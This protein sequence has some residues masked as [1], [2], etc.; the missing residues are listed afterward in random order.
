MQNTK[1]VPV[2]V[3]TGFL[4]SGKTTLLNHILSGQHNKKIAV[5]E[6]E[7]GEIGIDNELVI[8][9]DEEIFSLENGCICCTVRGDL[10]R[11]LGQLM[12]RKDKFDYILLETTG[13]ANPAPVAQTFFADEEMK[14]QFALDAIVT[15]VDSKFVWQ[16]ID[17]SPECQEQIAFADVLLLN[18]TDLVSEEE[19]QKLET[20][21]RQMNSQTKIY[22]S[23]KSEIDINLL[24]NV[25]AFDLENKALLNPEF[26]KKEHHDHEHDHGH[27]HGHHHHDPNHY[28]HEHDLA[29]TS[30]GLQKAGNL[31]P[32]RL[33]E[34]LS[35]LLGEKGEDIFRMKG[36][37]SVKGDPF[38]FIFQGVHMMFDQTQ[39]KKWES[40]S[41]RN[42]QLV[43]IGKNLDRKQLT[44]DF[45]ACFV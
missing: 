36:I 43:F 21:I 11:I 27:D 28:Y 8:S 5:I 16:H 10:I 23:K 15:V 29:V 25:R 22:R 2:T 4:G 18:K 9:A 6:N 24:L 20:R 44:A 14:E 40:D 26:L 12:R 1:K 39:G 45:E 33:Q 41:V 19:L 17:S 38:R 30:V 35:Y 37:L 42:N 31:D 34:W 32:L 13:L 3:L 7:F